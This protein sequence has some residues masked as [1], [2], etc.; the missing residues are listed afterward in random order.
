MT[1]L[2]IERILSL[3]VPFTLFRHYFYGPLFFTFQ[4][5]NASPTEFYRRKTQGY[6]K[7][8]REKYKD[9]R[10]SG[11]HRDKKSRE[12]TRQVSKVI[13]LSLSFFLSLSCRENDRN[14]RRQR[15]VTKPCLLNCCPGSHSQGTSKFLV[16]NSLFTVSL[17]RETRCERIN[18]RKGSDC[19]SFKSIRL[20]DAMSQKQNKM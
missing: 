20:Q 15:K 3:F 18:E 11:R 10:G 6:F 16:L 19:R 13:G 12:K 8:T 9:C 17:L 4:P 5:Y 1:C 2:A 14:T 7:L